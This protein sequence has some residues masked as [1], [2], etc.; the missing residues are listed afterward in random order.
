MPDVQSVQSALA[1][2]G[3]IAVATDDPDSI[4]AGSVAGSKR[5]FPPIFGI[6]PREYQESADGV[7]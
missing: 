3:R 7:A 1:F 6:P 4:G 2:S 5:V